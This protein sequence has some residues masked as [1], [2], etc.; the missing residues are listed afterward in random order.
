M[1]SLI[2]KNYIF[3]IR[4]SLM[5]GSNLPWLLAACT[6]VTGGQ[7]ATQSPRGLQYNRS[8]KM[9]ITIAMNLKSA[10]INRLFRLIGQP[11]LYT[12]TMNTD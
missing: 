3:F 8:P 6:H 10:L 5:L 11:L 4:L 12:R 2:L 9:Q 1:L 7:P